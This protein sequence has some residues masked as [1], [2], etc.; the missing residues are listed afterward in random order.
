MDQKENFSKAK[1][2]TSFKYVPWNVMGVEEQ[3][4]SELKT[5]P[6]FQFIRIIY[7]G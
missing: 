3:V 4:G 7:I 2:K 1:I 5:C 6:V